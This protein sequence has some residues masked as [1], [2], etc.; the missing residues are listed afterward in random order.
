VAFGVQLAKFEEL[1]IDRERGFEVAHSYADFLS[2]ALGCV[3]LLTLLMVF[4]LAVTITVTHK[5][6]VVSWPTSYV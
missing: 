1:R 3:F 6:F 2:F 4:K 5:F